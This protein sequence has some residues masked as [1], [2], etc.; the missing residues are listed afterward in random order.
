MKLKIYAVL[1][2]LVCLCSCSSVP[3]FDEEPL[4]FD[5]MPEWQTV[6]DGIYEYHFYDDEEKVKIHFV[7][8]DLSKVSFVYSKPSEGNLFEKETTYDFACK[9]NAIIAFNMSPFK[10]S[11]FTKF[12]VLGICVLDGKIIENPN[13]RYSDIRFWIEDEKPYAEIE[14]IQSLEDIDRQNFFAFGGFW[15]IIRDGKLVDSFK[16]ILDSRTAIGILPSGNIIIML[17]EG[18]GLRGL[19]YHEC[20]DILIKLGVVDAIQ[21]DGGGSSSMVIDDLVYG[22]KKRK[23]AVSLGFSKKEDIDE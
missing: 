20:A 12:E 7:K 13:E 4:S 9:N 22:S 15:Q 2:I 8:A 14:E 21:M 23:V 18:E 11:G 5:I 19:S 17:A 3:S 10:K 1:F 16:Q 6:Q